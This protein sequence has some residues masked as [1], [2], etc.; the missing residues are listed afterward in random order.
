MTSTQVS[1]TPHQQLYNTDFVEWADQT[2]ELLKQGKFSEL[3]IENLIEEVEDL[4]NR[5]RDALESQLTRLLMHLLKWQYQPDKRSGSWSG[6]IREA[7]KQ[8]RRLLRNY[9]SLKNHLT[10]KFDICYQDAVEDAAD[11][12]GL[13][14]ETFPADCP[15]TAEQTLDS[16]SLPEK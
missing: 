7:R 16:E 10:A 12:T 13:P 1:S 8:I 5:H 2:A 9:P 6:S 15:Y 4:G 3:D 14:L 11:E